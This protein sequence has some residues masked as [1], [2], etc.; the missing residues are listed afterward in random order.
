MKIAIVDDEDYWRKNTEQCIRKI[1]QTDTE[2]VVYDNPIS[3]LACKDDYDISLIDIE[4]PEMDGFETIKRAREKKQDGI[5]MI[6]TTHTE[7]SRKGYLVNAFRYL[8][9]KNLK[10]E[11]EEALLASKK[12]FEKN[13]KIILNIVGEAQQELALKNIYYFE[14]QKHGILIYTSLGVKRINDSMAEME[15]KLDNKWFYRCHNS[16]IVNLDEIEALK[17]TVIYMKNG[18]D[19]DISRRKVSEFKKTFLK[20]QYECANG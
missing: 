5:F 14:A 17:G 11:L 18:D 8:D 2:V 7:M 12:L 9:K 10:E 3:Y 4:M 15:Q 6:L 20:R 19:I 1:E 16:F 13:K